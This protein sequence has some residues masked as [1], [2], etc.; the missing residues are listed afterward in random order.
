M[1]FATRKQS[2]EKVMFSQ[3]CVILPTSGGGGGVYPS[4]QWGR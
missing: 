1:F 3:A 2:N 4:M